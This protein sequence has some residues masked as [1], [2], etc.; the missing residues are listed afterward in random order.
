M[1]FQDNYILR[2]D[3]KCEDGTHVCYENEE[4][5]TDYIIP[6]ECTEIVYCKE[7]S[8]KTYSANLVD[9]MIGTDVN[10]SAADKVLIAELKGEGNKEITFSR[11]ENPIVMK[12]TDITEHEMFGFPEISRNVLTS[13]DNGLWS[14]HGLRKLKFNFENLQMEGE[15]W[16]ISANLVLDHR[17]N[18]EMLAISSEENDILQNKNYSSASKMI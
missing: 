15:E 2:V 16:E 11:A 5:V 10:I 4:G 3:C 14:Y 17:E 1:A 7:G 18:D 9:M 13:S 8:S 6:N 12:Y